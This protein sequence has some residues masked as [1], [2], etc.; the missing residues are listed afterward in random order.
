MLTESD[1]F[2]YFF[3]WHLLLIGGLLPFVSITFSTDFFW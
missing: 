1:L 3:F 2:I